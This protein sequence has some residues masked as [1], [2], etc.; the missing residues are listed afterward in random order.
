MY[1]EYIF[2]ISYENKTLQLW[3]K[4]STE[5]NHMNFTI[6]QLKR[7]VLKKKKKKHFGSIGRVFLM[8]LKKKEKKKKAF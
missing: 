8:V 2:F 3:G 7:Y 1:I 6:Y 4:N 5:L